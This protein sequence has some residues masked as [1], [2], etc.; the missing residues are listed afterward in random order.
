MIKLR[1]IVLL[2]AI[3]VLGLLN[4]FIYWNS[5]LY[6]RA[7]KED[8]DQ[9]KIRLLEES[10]KLYPLNDLVFYELGKSYLDFGLMRLNDAAA[11]ESSFRKSVQNLRKSI[12]I[13]PASP[14]SHFYLGQ[15]LLNLALFSSGK[16]TKFYDEFR[17]AALLSGD[18]SQIFNE[19]GRLFLSRWPELSPED[20][21]FTLEILR[22]V[23]GNKDQEKIAL[24]LNIWELNAKDYQII[25][26]IL[27]ADAQVYR[28]YAEF[29]G[30]KSLFLEERHKYLAL[31]DILDFARAKSEFQSGEMQLGRFQTE[32]AF[33]HFKTSLDLLGG[34][35]FYQASVVKDSISNSEY[36]DLLKS[37]LLDLAKC[38]IEEGAGLS[39]VV[40]YLS[41]Y[42]SLEDRTA[43]IGELER[44]LR[45]RGA[46]PGKFDKSSNDL[47]RLAIELSF[48]FKQT[49]FREIVNFGRELEKSFVVVPEAKKQDY[50]RI[51]LLVGDSYQKVDF[52]YD[53]G[54]IY[55]KALDIG[56]NN[57]ETLLRIRNNSDR[58][59]EDKKLEEINK[60]IEKLMAPKEINLQSL[61]LNKGEMFSRSLILDGQS[62]VLDLQFQTD[63]KSEA[64]LISVF[65]N[66]RVVWDDYLKDSAIIS[67][68]LETKAGDNALQI[69]PINLPISLTKLT[70]RLR[71]ENENLSVLRR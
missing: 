47:T 31:A 58:L 13:N 16:D 17:K 40:T 34:I 33:G 66:N 63:E 68:P 35:R 23:V 48:Q 7:Q 30:E 62:V 27:P 59:N 67:L 43:K 52:L 69:I 20:Q 21:N 32:E 5:H 38:R 64:P 50:V 1:Q 36:T 45:D 15:S 55:Q 28:Q 18:G 56:P 26:K 53:A 42:L 39:E 22:K 25:E 37:T 71:N 46:L 51:L 65:F 8:D 2:F 60:V 57:L 9:K 10:N 12:L 29:L 70:Y 4:I 19:V 41:Q 44:Y 54:D 14:F 49:K 24:L 11:S 3:F 61:R 6:Y